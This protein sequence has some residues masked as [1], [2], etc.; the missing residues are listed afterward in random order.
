MTLDDTKSQSYY[1]FNFWVE[2]MNEI[3]KNPDQENPGTNPDEQ[4]SGLVPDEQTTESNT[5]DQNPDTKPN[6]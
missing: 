6:E 2:D 1:V 3:N 4:T 5:V